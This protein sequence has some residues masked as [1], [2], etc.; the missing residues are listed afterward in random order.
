M[1]I[2]AD[3]LLDRLY[4]KSQISKWRILTVVFGIIAL[5][6]VFERS[7]TH[8][9]IETPF[10]ARLPIEGF[11]EDDQEVYRLIED[12]AENSKAKAVILWLDTPGGSAVGGEEL[13]T[14]LRALAAKKPV[15]A[16]M[17]S[18]SASAGYM[19]AISSDYIVAREGTITGSIGVLMEAAEVTELAEK[20]GIK[21]IIIK[22]SPLK[23]TPSPLEKLTP[24][25]TRVVQEAINDFYNRFVDMVAERRQ[26]PREKVVQLADGRIYS[27]RRA[28]ENKLVDALGG[29]EEAVKWLVSQRKIA[30][31]LD[32]RDIGPEEELPWFE[33]LTQSVASNF[34]QTRSVTLDGLAAIWHPQLH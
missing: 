2:N 23:G 18:V 24:E 32:I 26:L 16:V 1:A 13:Y 11:I 7:S 17:R 34:F 5:I 8:S 31:D 21:P 20:L 33:R 12:L 15:V 25:S 14:K 30:P 10:I 29:E 27:G 22:S 9:P 3:T 19:V 4:L 6:A 28:L